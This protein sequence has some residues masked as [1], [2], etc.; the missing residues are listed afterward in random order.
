M[1]GVLLA[2]GVCGLIA[3]VAMSK[4][5]Y[6]SRQPGRAAADMAPRPGTGDVPAWISGMYLLSILVAVVGL[7]AGSSR[8]SLDDI[9]AA[10]STFLL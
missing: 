3:A 7:I 2:V 6:E 4:A 1:S 8:S 9:P 5:A 10:D